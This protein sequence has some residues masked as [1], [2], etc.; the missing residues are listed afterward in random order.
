MPR[1]NQIFRGI[2]FRDK[3]IGQCTVIKNIDELPYIKRCTNRCG[4]GLT[5]CLEHAYAVTFRWGDPKRNQT[6]STYFSSKVQA[7]HFR[8]TQVPLTWTETNYKRNRF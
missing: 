5:V 4:T 6:K 8:T 1:L 3:K 7:E 2:S